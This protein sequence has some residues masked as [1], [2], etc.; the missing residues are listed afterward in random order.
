MSAA[1]IAG[2]SPQVLARAGGAC[3]LM[4]ILTGILALFAR[5]SAGTAVL[6]ASTIFY[7]AATY[8]VY[9][10]LKPVSNAVSALAA[11]FSGVGCVLSTLDAFDRSPVD[12]NP[13]VFFGLHCL[14]V[15]L[16]IFRSTFLP[17]ILAVLMMFAGVGWLTSMSPALAASL[18]PFNMIPGVLGETTL[19]LWLLVKGVN[20][21]KWAESSA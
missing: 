15:G 10:L 18:S 14:L 11:F 4:T 17:R 9:Q 5:G 3:W 8:F 19:S 12:T 7:A 20:A 2:S 1:G 6:L 21:T 16:L 13:L